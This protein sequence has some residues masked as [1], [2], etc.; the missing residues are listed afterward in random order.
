MKREESDNH[1]SHTSKVRRESHIANQ[2]LLSHKQLQ[3]ERRESI[4][5]IKCMLR[6]TPATGGEERGDIE[7]IKCCAHHTPAT[8]GRGRDV[9]ETIKCMPLINTPAKGGEGERGTIEPIKV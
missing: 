4:E 3:V 7:P 6:H 2:V 1:G 8:G 5:P 9:I